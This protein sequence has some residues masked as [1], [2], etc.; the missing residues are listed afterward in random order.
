MAT[1]ARQGR[2]EYQFIFVPWFWQAEYEKKT[3]NAVELNA[4][5]IA[6][7]KNFS[8]STGQMLWRRQKIEELGSPQTF[9]R[10]Y[11]ATAE[12]AFAIDQPGALWNRQ[13]IQTN[14]RHAGSVPDL[15]RVV[16]AVDPATRKGEQNNETGI[17]VAGLGADGHAYI[18]EDVSGH[19]T[20]SEWA[21]HVIAAYARHRADVV[22]AEVN[23]GGDMVEQTLRAFDSQISFK[24]VFASRGKVTRAE[25]IAA[26]D[27]RGWVHHVG[28]FPAL[29]DQMCHFD[30]RLI[31]HSPD[32]VDAR[33]WALTELLLNHKSPSSPLIWGG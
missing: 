23:Q 31:T 17:I 26:F 29:E 4:E 13:I 22:V 6:Y 19:Y 30:P 15:K 20:P 1:T 3:L 10:E 25:P 32:R 27:A 7:Q 2:S 8:L 12:E 28:I 18:L 9:Q 16:V 24:A 14:R 33:V 5:E 21:G 11:P